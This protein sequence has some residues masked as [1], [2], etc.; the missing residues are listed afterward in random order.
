MAPGAMHGPLELE[1]I[2]LAEV[3]DT[4]LEPLTATMCVGLAPL[5]LLAANCCNL[6][7]VFIS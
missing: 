2:K 3:I 7:G 4:P 1:E 6:D 5:A